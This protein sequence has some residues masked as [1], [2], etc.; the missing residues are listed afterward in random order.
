M[1]TLK[2][3]LVALLVSF[4]MMSMAQSNERANQ[5]VISLEKAITIPQLNYAM[6]QQIDLKSFLGE[7]RDGLYVAKVLVQGKFFF[8]SGTYSQWYDFL[9]TRLEF[10]PREIRIDR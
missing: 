9:T 5:K 10:I 4:T 3:G 1:K 2:L 7:E 6:H 8:V